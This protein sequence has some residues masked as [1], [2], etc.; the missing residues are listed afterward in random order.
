MLLVTVLLA[1]LTRKVYSEQQNIILYNATSNNNK[2]VKLASTSPS[3]VQVQC[4]NV[5]HGQ[6]ILR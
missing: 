5:H 4:A 6:F 2:Q 1:E 3:N